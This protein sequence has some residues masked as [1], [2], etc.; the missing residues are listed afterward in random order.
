MKLEY[1]NANA[2]LYEKFDEMKKAYDE[3]K[4]GYDDTPHCFYSLEFVPYILKHL[5]ENSEKELKKIF[6]FVEQLMS[7]CDIYLINLAEVSI[8]EPLYFDDVNIDHK[9]AMLKYG[10]KL[11]LQSFIDCFD[12]EEMAGWEKTES[13][14]MH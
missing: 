9:A 7:S 6:D 11:T 10:G 1:S 2:L 13:S 12:D 5:Q 4:D 3:D 14:L 8:I